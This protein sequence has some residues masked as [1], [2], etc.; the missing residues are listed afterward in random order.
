MSMREEHLIKVAISLF[1]FMLLFISIFC[2]EQ[3]LRYHYR[4]FRE[5]Y[6]QNLLASCKKLNDV[7]IKKAQRY[8]I[9][10]TTLT[11]VSTN[12]KY[13]QKNEIFHSFEIGWNK[14]EFSLNKILVM[15]GSL[16]MTVSM[17]Q[18]YVN[19][20][21]LIVQ[22][23]YTQTA[24]RLTSVQNQLLSCKYAFIYHRQKIAHTLILQ[25]MEVAQG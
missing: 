7:S 13:I 2:Q 17:C 24:Q 20:L 3:K 5:L 1:L 9:V 4:E 18:Q 19:K 12:L 15:R 14:D 16:E 25:S 22:A 10:Y 11:F 8:V 6:A 21:I 23:L